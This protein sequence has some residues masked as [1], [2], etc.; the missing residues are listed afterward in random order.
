MFLFRITILFIFLTFVKSGLAQNTNALDS[1][2]VKNINLVYQNPE[3][4]N[5]V[6]SYLFEYAKSKKEKIEGLYLFSESNF[7]KGNYNISIEQV[8][9]A[10]LLCKTTNETTLK[11]LI[12]TT[13]ANRCRIFGVHDKANAYI[14]KS[15]E[16]LPKISFKDERNMCEAKI[17]LEQSFTDLQTKNYDQA[18]TKLQNGYIKLKDINDRFPVLTAKIIIAIGDIETMLMRYPNAE[19]QYKIAISIL[20]RNELEN[21]TIAANAFNGLGNIA[22]Q[23][24]NYEIADTQLNKA[25]AFPIVDMYTKSVIFKNKSDVYKAQ[26]KIEKQKLY[27]QYYLDLNEEIVSNERFSRNS[28]IKEIEKDES[29][30]IVNEKKSYNFIFTLLIVIMMILFL[31]FYYFNRKLNREHK[32]FE[33]LLEKRKNEKTIKAISEKGY[34]IEI[35]LKKGINIPDKTEQLILDK[36]EEFEASTFYTNPSITLQMLAKKLK[37]N[38]KYLSEV[39]HIHKNKNFNN[40]INELRINYIIDLMTTDRKYLNYKVSYLAETCG[41]SSHSAFSAVFKSITKLTPKQFVSFLKKK[42]EKQ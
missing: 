2:F 28:I 18:L 26:K 13:I 7:I 16:L 39:I 19:K 12:L 37:T 32:Q 9:E 11:I 29:Y 41:Y 42:N 10:N 27:Y 1:I 17:L 20:K 36:L 31:L 34:S 21:S 30:L 5:K 23:E 6:A 22:L 4:A 40:Y 33:A 8:Y 3:Q 38:T 24:Q 15:I 25:Q 35:K 14:K